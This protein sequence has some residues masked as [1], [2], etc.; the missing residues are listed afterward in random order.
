MSTIGERI[1]D[2]VAQAFAPKEN[3]VKIETVKDCEIA[4]DSGAILLPIFVMLS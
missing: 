2:R 4:P 3:Q 1:E